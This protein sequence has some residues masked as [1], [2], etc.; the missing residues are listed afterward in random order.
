M[1]AGSAYRVATPGRPTGGLRC[2]RWHA[3]VWL[4]CALVSTCV[5]AA[6]ASA[7]SG[8]RGTVSLSP[9]CGGAQVEGRDC[10][11]AYA[12]V[13]VR[14]LGAADAVVATA[15][16]SPAGAYRLPAPAG[17]YV[18]KVMTPVKITRCPSPAVT[19]RSGAETETVID[20]DCD[21]G[22]R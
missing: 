3:P 9:A 13:E 17:H 10:R 8:V 11:A 12:D 19:V 21:S 15:R 7:G 20:I 1:A 14:L 18:L 5:V 22:M 16:T 2:M 6:T 4:A